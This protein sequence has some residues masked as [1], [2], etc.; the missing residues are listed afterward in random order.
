MVKL[1]KSITQRENIMHCLDV[2]VFELVDLQILINILEI[3]NQQFLATV[4]NYPQQNGNL[5]L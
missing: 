4:V 1:G 2:P 3:K 5:S